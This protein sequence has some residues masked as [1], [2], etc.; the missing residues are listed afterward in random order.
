MFDG[1]NRIPTFGRYRKFLNA[2]KGNRYDNFGRC[3]QETIIMLFLTVVVKNY[4]NPIF[5]TYR[6]YLQNVFLNVNKKYLSELL[7][8]ALNLIKFGNCAAE[9]AVFKML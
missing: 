4:E 8:I 5:Q 2:I 1:F 9:P 7:A 6:K 3:K